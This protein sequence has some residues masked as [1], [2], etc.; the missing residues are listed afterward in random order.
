MSKSLIARVAS[1]KVNRPKLASSTS[2]FMKLEIAVA[3]PSRHSGGISRSQPGIV[4]SGRAKDATASA[5][6]PIQTTSVAE[7]LMSGERSLQR[8]RRRH[9]ASVPPMSTDMTAARSTTP[10]SLPSASCTANA[11]P[12]ASTS[13]ANSATLLSAGM[14]PATA[15]PLRLGA[16]DRARRKDL[17]P[18]RLARKLGDI[19][20]GRRQHQLLR[21]ADLHDAPVLHDGDAVGE[22]D[23]LVEIVRDEDDGLLQHRLQPQKLVLH[24]PPDQRIE[25]GERLVEKPDVRVGGERAGDADALLLTA[26]ELV[27]QIVLAALETDERGH[28]PRARLALLARHALDLERKRHIV[29]HGEMRQQREVLKHHAHLVTPELD[30]LLP[31]RRRAGCGRR[32]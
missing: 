7:V 13:L 1:L 10:T 30:Q 18:R 20:V 17:R 12:E 32:T 19:A 4:P 2:Q 23:R 22:P 15:S 11:S 26:G 5:A 14:L 25:R 31:A 21:R 29:E 27:R 28:L 8:H 24:L 6:K 3:N 9:G 16:G